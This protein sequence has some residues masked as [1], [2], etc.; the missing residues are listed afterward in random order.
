M[1]YCLKLWRLARTDGH[2]DTQSATVTCSMKRDNSYRSYVSHE[3]LVPEL[4]VTTPDGCYYLLVNN[5]A[6]TPV[7]TDVTDTVEMVG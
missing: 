3:D 7:K 6:T 2:G 5:K 1:A 4:G